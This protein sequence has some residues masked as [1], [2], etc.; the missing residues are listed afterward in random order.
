MT[1]SRIVVLGMYFASVAFSGGYWYNGLP[2]ENATGDGS[3]T[4]W[5]EGLPVLAIEATPGTSGGFVP[6][7]INQ[8]VI[9]KNNTTHRTINMI[10]VIIPVRAGGNADITLS[11]LSKQEQSGQDMEIIVQHDTTPGG[12]AAI[13]RNAGFERSR[14]EFVLF[15]DDDIDWRSTALYRLHY[16]LSTSSDCAYSYGPYL[17]DGRIHCLRVF[18]PAILRR[19][20]YIST[21]SLIRREHFPGFD[22]DVRRLQDWDLWLTLLEQGHH[23]VFCGPEPLFTT[24]RRPGITFHGD[25]NTVGGDIINGV[26]SWRYAEWYV[27]RKHGLEP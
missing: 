14:G 11:S 4:Y 8:P 26:W 12:N 5:R 24:Q 17:M 19:V 6:A 25:E 13:T 21:M 1:G 7:I 22:P 16:W 9:S 27:K 15:S 3:Q 2:F 23:G 20:N 18:D 10:S